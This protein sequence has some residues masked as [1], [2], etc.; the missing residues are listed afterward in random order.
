MNVNV[1]L[2]EI[3]HKLDKESDF[4]FRFSLVL[5][6]SKITKVNDLNYIHSFLTMFMK[7]TSKK[8]IMDE[9]KQEK[10][11]YYNFI[12][13]AKFLVLLFV[14]PLKICYYIL[15]ITLL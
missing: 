12:Y 10:L 7:N 13:F 11:R 8:Y 9:S 4:L 2:C 5:K 15:C 1:S 14:E 6:F 3:A